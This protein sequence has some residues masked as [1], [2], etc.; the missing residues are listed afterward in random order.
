MVLKEQLTHDLKEA[1]RA[2]DSDTRDT[3]RMLQAAIKQVEID[4][5]QA[6]D[7]EGVLV[8]LSKQ[9]KQRRESISEYQKAG[10]DDL[11]EPEQRDLVVIERYLPSMM[12]R[13]EIE[14][15]VAAVIADTG[16]SSPQD[17]GKVMGPV[18]AELKGKADG[19]LVNQVVRD[20]LSS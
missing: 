16:A 19:K 14:T 18:M 9:A 15:V 4:S 3:L 5:G 2:Q 20:L 10:R 8:V 11:V 12:E 17:M 7:D 1:M 13:P 6:L